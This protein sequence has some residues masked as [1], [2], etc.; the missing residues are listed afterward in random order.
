LGLKSEVGVGSAEHGHRNL[1]D[2]SVKF[3][4]LYFPPTPSLCSSAN[5]QLQCGYILFFFK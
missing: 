1:L 5:S 4:L 3:S 2:S